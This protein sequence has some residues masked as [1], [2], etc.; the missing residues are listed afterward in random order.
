MTDRERLLAILSGQSPDRIP[1]IP[2]LQLWYDA[3]MTQGNMPERWQGW[4]LRDIERD[5]GL[6]AP[7]RSGRV[8]RTELR[9]VEQRIRE[10]GRDTI[11]EYITPLGAV[12]TRVRRSE[13]L[14]EVGIEGLEVEKMI[15]DVADYPAVEYII[16]HTDIIPT[17]DEFLAYDA[18][19]GEE[20]LPMVQIDP[21]PMFRVLREFIGFD[22]A[23]YHLLDYP[24]EVAHLLAV[25]D[26]WA[27]E[28]QRVVLD[29]PATLILGGVHFHA[30]MTPPPLFREHM[31]PY[32]QEFARRL[33]ARGKALACHADA[34]TSGLLEL[35]VEA[36]FDM[37]E[38]FVTA[39]MVPVTLAQAREAFGTNVSSGTDVSSGTRV[40]IWGGVPS[41]ILGDPV[42]DD[43]F[44]DY[45][46]NLF[47]TIAP[48][49]AFILG[50][51]DNVMP[52]SKIERIARISE[53]VEVHGAYP[54][55]AG[56]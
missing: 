14:D 35:I 45:M 5:L 6:G 47:R 13:A 37:A 33:H 43:A 10:E 53:M 39:P 1:W 16:A 51:A 11:T 42:S 12:S 15:K 9:G 40:I 25:L 44:E 3:R 34:D 23:Y 52:E 19:I 49:D 20:G 2:R 27:G 17:Y 46:L 18:E 26:E 29:S 38:C 54:V 24:A 31:L 7:A 8:Y 4:A 30:Q 32:F 56:G 36:G 22:N 48:G 50:V 28:M 55:A 21:D 41:V